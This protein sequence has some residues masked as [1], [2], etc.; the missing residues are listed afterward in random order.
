MLDDYEDGSTGFKGVFYGSDGNE[1]SRD[2]VNKVLDIV[3][4]SRVAL[5]E[6]RHSQSDS[7]NA[8][9]V[10]KSQLDRLTVEDSELSVNRELVF[11]I[12]DWFLRYETIENGCDGM[13]DVSV[14][15]YTDWTDL[16]DGSLLNFK[17]G[18]RS[19]LNWFCN[20]FP[21]K[22]WI[23]LNRQVKK[24]E[25]LTAGP[26]ERWHDEAGSS[27]EK[28]ILVKYGLNPNKASKRCYLRIIE[29]DHVVMTASLG[30]L[31]Q[32]HETIFKPPLPDLK[33][34]LIQSIGFGTVNKI[35]LQFER[36]FWK[37]KHGFKL[38]WT[39]EEERVKFPRWAHDIIAFDVVRRQPNLLIGWI[40][41]LGAKLME[42][43]T[44]FEIAKTCLEIMRQFLSTE[45]KYEP[46]KLISC[47]C[48]RW[49]SNP[50]VCGS[51]SYLSMDSFG[52]NVERLHDPV[53][54]LA[55]ESS[56]LSP[57]NKIPRILFAGEA[58]AGKLYSTTHGA[59]ITGWR[60][61]DRLKDHL[62]S[63]LQGNVRTGDQNAAK[64]HI[65]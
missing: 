14:A 18:Y 32:N 58:T 21:A 40:G 13:H 17:L 28:P 8:A 54:E 55:E 19:L 35:I 30:F 26:N 44:D 20:Q 25:M 9:E 46:T 5:S 59:I 31:K 61:A 11:A 22:K 7:N 65:Q 39:S 6:Y 47:I 43:E 52:R 3:M 29:C 60:E 37:D 62:C 24:V 33:R 1:V 63:D 12:F 38:I 34:E 16:G 64:Y 51:Y 36:P 45:S 57:T 42:Q 56:K 49:N 15:S 10:F 27:F 4:D 2:L 41:G 48:S 50:F 53:Y 23:L